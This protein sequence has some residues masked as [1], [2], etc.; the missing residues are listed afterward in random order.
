MGLC[1][2]GGRG[3]FC[4]L[5]VRGEAF[6]KC[7]NPKGVSFCNSYKVGIVIPG[8]VHYSTFRK[9]S[10]NG[11]YYNAIYMI[12]NTLYVRYILY[13]RYTLYNIHTLYIM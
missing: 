3:V 7:F 4:D 9:Y 1:Q 8:D 12:Y 6:F 2:R 11:S 10:E 13:V 5:S